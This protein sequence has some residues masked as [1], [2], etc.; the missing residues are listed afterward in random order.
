MAGRGRGSLGEQVAQG[1][2][3]VVAQDSWS[4]AGSGPAA[5]AEGPIREE[6]HLRERGQGQDAGSWA[7]SES[8]WRKVAEAGAGHL[9]TKVR[10]GSAGEEV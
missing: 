6:A 8:G 5:R 1:S 7:E 2:R 3:N 10:A 4:G 9:G